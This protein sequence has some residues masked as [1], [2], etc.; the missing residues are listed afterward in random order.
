[1]FQTVCLSSLKHVSDGIYLVIK[2]CFRWYASRHQNTGLFGKGLNH[3]N[4][5]TLANDVKGNRMTNNELCTAQ[6]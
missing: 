6:V 2:T 1:M 5:L 4:E 3:K